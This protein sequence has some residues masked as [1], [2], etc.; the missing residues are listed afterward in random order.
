MTIQGKPQPAPNRD[1]SFPSPQ[2]Q[3]ATAIQSDDANTDHSSITPLLYKETEAAIFLGV[4]ASQLRLSRHTGELF[5]GIP[6]PPFIKLSRAVRY[7]KEDLEAWVN[8]FQTY[9][10]TLDAQLDLSREK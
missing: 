6:T 7:K 1:Y 2:N 5:K 3:L 10:T 8:Q 4:S 9:K